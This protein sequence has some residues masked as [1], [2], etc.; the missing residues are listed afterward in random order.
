M[1]RKIPVY[2]QGRLIEVSESDGLNVDDENTHIMS[3]WDS[4]STE[5]SDTSTIRNSSVASELLG[6]AYKNSK[7]SSGSSESEVSE[8]ELESESESEQDR[9]LLISESELE[10]DNQLS[11]RVVAYESE[12]IPQISSSL[13]SRLEE[14][15]K[16]KT[17][18][19]KV[20]VKHRKQKKDKVK[21]L[22][23]PSK[24]LVMGSKD[25]VIDIEEFKKEWEEHDKA[26]EEEFDL[27]TTE[28]L[29][30]DKKK[31]KKFVS[32]LYNEIQSLRNFI[33][34]EIAPLEFAV[35]NALH[36]AKQELEGY[37]DLDVTQL[38]KTY[39]SALND[40]VKI[41]I[42]NYIFS[43]LALTENQKRDLI[44]KHL[45]LSAEEYDRY[46]ESN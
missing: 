26:V 39:E 46:K 4:D 24:F 33:V 41:K 36:E 34:E 9:V 31:K 6:A 35:P 21:F 1:T 40:A 29:K 25:E 44:I 17:L 28:V 20:F 2:I 13:L 10:S 38:T 7:H 43:R 8:S 14:V 15:D 3:D 16:E 42:L 12:A 18:E 23:K 30:I 5:E 32:E 45:K 27:S 11:D 22:S 19:T 37:L